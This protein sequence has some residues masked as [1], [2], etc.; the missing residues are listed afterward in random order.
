MAERSGVYRVKVH[1]NI[2]FHW[3]IC[4]FVSWSFGHT[5]KK[6]SKLRI[7]IAQWREAAFSGQMINNTEKALMRFALHDISSNEINHF[8]APINLHCAWQGIFALT[9]EEGNSQK[10]QI[11]LELDYSTTIFAEIWH[12]PLRHQCGWGRAMPGWHIII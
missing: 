2:L 3:P 1:G 7:I 4:H 6:T 9:V 12:T 5:S 11:W 10:W 8:N